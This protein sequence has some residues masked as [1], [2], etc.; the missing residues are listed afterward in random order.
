MY[1][2]HTFVEARKLER[3]HA[4]RVHLRRAGLEMQW[5]RKF[6]DFG[7]RPVLAIRWAVQSLGRKAA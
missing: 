5:S 3:E 6:T 7:E 2:S 4:E 1:S